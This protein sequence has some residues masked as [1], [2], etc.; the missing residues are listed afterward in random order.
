MSPG[1][2]SL[3]IQS[4]AGQTGLQEMTS[5]GSHLVRPTDKF[6]LWPPVWMNEPNTSYP[7]KY[8]LKVNST[9]CTHQSFFFYRSWGVGACSINPPNTFRK[10]QWTASVCGQQLQTDAKSVEFAFF[11]VKLEHFTYWESKTK[12]RIW[13]I[14]CYIYIKIN[15]C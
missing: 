7:G 15:D 3:L 4:V 8:R 11:R 6:H 13:L 9:D 1:S 2:V 14:C 12:S 10:I 5:P